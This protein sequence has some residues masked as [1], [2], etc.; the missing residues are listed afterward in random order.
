MEY[1]IDRARETDAVKVIE[2]SWCSYRDYQMFKLL[3]YAI[4]AAVSGSSAIPFLF[5]SLELMLILNSV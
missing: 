5:L 1:L 3:K 4:C 2:R